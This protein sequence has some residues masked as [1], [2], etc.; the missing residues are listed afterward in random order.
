MFVSLL[1]SY[2]NMGAYRRVSSRG[3]TWTCGRVG[4]TPGLSKIELQFQ[5]IRT[6]TF[7]AWKARFFELLVNS[8]DNSLCGS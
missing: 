3:G 2:L 8:S 5:S 7:H 1:S 6:G 4:G